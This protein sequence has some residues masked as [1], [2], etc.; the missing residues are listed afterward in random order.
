M[1]IRN[2]MHNWNYIWK[3][4]SKWDILWYILHVAGLSQTNSGPIVVCRIDCVTNFNYSAHANETKLT[5]KSLRKMR[6]NPQSVHCI[7]RTKVIWKRKNVLIDEQTSMSEQREQWTVNTLDKMWVMNSSTQW[8]NR[9][10]CM[11]LMKTLRDF[12]Q[13]KSLTRKA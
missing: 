4:G 8:I 11:R 10:S 3:N 5:N 2:W 13:S 6:R 9:V 12:T 1:F 7:R